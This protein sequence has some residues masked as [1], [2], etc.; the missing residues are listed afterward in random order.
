MAVIV[1]AW[2]SGSRTRM[3]PA[4]GRHELRVA[5]GKIRRPSA[6]ICAESEGCE[7]LGPI[8]AWLK[9]ALPATATKDWSGFTSRP[10]RLASANPKA[11][12][13]IE[14]GKP[15]WIAANG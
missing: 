7:T 14:Q 3:P 4:F 11:L 8:V 2:C 12:P 1:A 9:E 10:N 6:W 15:Y 5:A 13:I